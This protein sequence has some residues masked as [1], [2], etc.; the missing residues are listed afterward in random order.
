MRFSGA[1]DIAKKRNWPVSKAG[2]QVPTW[3][4]LVGFLCVCSDVAWFRWGKARCGDSKKQLGDAMIF[5]SN[6]PPLGSY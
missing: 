2:Q 6:F 5:R 1:Y 3:G 4:G